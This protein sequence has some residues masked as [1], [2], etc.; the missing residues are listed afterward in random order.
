MPLFSDPR[1]ALLTIFLFLQLCFVLRVPAPK[2]G[3]EQMKAKVFDKHNVRLALM[4][5]YYGALALS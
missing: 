3:R 2:M 1:D 4:K 5:I